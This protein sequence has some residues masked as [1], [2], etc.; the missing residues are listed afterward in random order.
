MNQEIIRRRNLPHW[1]KPAAAYFVTTCLHGSIPAK[2][3]L[4][5][6]SR[7]QELSRRPRPETMPLPEWKR[8]NWKRLLARIDGWLDNEPANRSPADPKLAAVVADAV[9]HFAGTR[10]ELY[11]FVVMPSHY[12]WLFRPLESW[13]D[14]LADPRTPRERITYS[15]NRFSAT[16]GNRLMQRIGPF[17]LGESYDHW[18]Q[19]VDEL[20]R[21]IG[22]IE[23]NPVKAGLTQRPEEFQFSSARLRRKLGLDVGA[24]LVLRS[25]GLES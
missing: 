5:I 1:D 6:A 9:L 3:L 20:E 7:R 15:V 14:G 21:I 11:A 25:S 12:H 10:L 4:D 17:W 8:D 22:Y 24:P 23:V 18:V 13:V 2:G 19:D 16:R